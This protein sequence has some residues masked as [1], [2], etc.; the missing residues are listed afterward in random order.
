MKKNNFQ[1]LWP[2]QK[3]SILQQ[4]DAFQKMLFRQSDN[5]IV[6]L[7]VGGVL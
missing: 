2:S 1:I 7:R 5:S 4:S 6:H 3:T